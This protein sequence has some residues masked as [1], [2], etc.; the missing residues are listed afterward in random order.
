MSA[1]TPSE[2]IL[3]EQQRLAQIGAARF[4]AA[5][6]TRHFEPVKVQFQ[7]LGEEQAVA[8]FIAHKNWELKSTV[9]ENGAVT[10]VYE[11]RP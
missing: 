10:L 2:D 3:R 8:C 11:K 4:Q 1:R 6:S 9:E 5:C 7:L